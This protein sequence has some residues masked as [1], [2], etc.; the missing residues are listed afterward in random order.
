[1]KEQV[2]SYDSATFSC[3]LLPAGLI[4]AMASEMY[5]MISNQ[6]KTDDFASSFN[7]QS[8]ALNQVD[9]HVCCLKSSVC[10][11]AFRVIRAVR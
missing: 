9:Y 4:C 10:R 8:G 11:L 2:C 7:V 5:N 6:V 1:L 3:F